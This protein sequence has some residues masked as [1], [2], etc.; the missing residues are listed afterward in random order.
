MNEPRKTSW[1]LVIIISVLLSGLILA[2]F[3][4][5]FLVQSAGSFTTIMNPDNSTI[6]AVQVATNF[7]DVNFSDDTTVDDSSIVAPTTTGTW[8]EFIS[9]KIPI[10]F[11]YPSTWQLFEGSTPLSEGIQ[12]GDY[13]PSTAPAT[14]FAVPPG[15]KL[16]ITVLPES[17]TGVAL[18]DAMKQADEE[19]IGQAGTITSITVDAFPAKL[20]TMVLDYAIAQ[21][22]IIPLG[23][24]SGNMIGISLYGPETD[25]VQARVLLDS[26]LTTV[27]IIDNNSNVTTSNQPIEYT[28]A[29]GPICPVDIQFL[30]A[31]NSPTVDCQCSN[32]YTMNRTMIGSSTGDA[33]YGPGTECP[34]FGVQCVRN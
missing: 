9:R 20:D 3:V 16:E 31:K 13:D 27:H 23:D 21:T 34:M 17:T 25:I 18:E 6:D 8:T 12:I 4:I 15:H 22:V 33:C 29:Y 19:Y 28:D 10:Q 5:A 24:G 26:I 1:I 11:S 7:D 30:S 32:G 14:D 2:G